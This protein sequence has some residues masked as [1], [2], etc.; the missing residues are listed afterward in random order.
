MRRMLAALSAAAMLVSVGFAEAAEEQRG[1]IKD[2]D[3]ANMTLTL[4]DGTTYE[5]AEGVKVID[6]QPGQEVTVSYEMKDG[7]KVADKITVNE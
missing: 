2:V 1:K 6:L 7:K 3:P 4:E 5:L